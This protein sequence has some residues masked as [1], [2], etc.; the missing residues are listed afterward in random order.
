MNIFYCIDCVHKCV[1]IA[2]NLSA[3]CFLFVWD[4]FSILSWYP[5]L[6]CLHAG[7]RYDPFHDVKDADV[8][9]QSYRWEAPRPKFRP[10]FRCISV[11][12]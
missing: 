5:I 10:V 6:L 7:R 8:P 4:A 9:F 12:F 1:L 3:A 2:V 11:V